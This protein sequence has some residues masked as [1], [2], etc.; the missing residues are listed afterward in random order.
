M[1]IEITV[2]ASEA[3]GFANEATCVATIVPV[4]IG[5]IGMEGERGEMG[6]PWTEEHPSK[7]RGGRT[8]SLSNRTTPPWS[9]IFYSRRRSW[10]VCRRVEGVSRCAGG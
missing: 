7:T 2:C 3:E 9:S 1:E 4:G 10:F 6:A 5:G 8:C